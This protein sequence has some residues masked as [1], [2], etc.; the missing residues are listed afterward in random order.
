MINQITSMAIQITFGI[1]IDKTITHGMSASRTVWQDLFHLKH[2]A[3][4][5][6]PFK[7]GQNLR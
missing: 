3:Y 5:L 2:I 6:A 7:R 4:A 1:R